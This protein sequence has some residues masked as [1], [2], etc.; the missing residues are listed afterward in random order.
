MHPCAC[1]QHDRRGLDSFETKGNTQKKCYDE[2][3][4]GIII[5]RLYARLMKALT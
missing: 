4:T 1:P 2:T 3:H 5:S